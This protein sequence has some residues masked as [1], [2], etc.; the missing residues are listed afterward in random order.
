MDNTSHPDNTPQAMSQPL[1]RDEFAQIIDNA[2]GKLTHYHKEHNQLKRDID[3]LKFDVKKLNSVI[4]SYEKLNKP[5][6]NFDRLPN[7]NEILRRS[8][9]FINENPL[10]FMI[11]F[12][13]GYFAVLSYVTKRT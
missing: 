7:D 5:W 13:A 12:V 6:Y 4:D 8:S 10:K 3:S 2:M 9:R 11:V 1:T